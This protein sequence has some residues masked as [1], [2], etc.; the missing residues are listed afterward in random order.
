[1]IMK[2]RKLNFSEHI[3]NVLAKTAVKLNSI[4]RLAKYMGNNN[5]KNKNNNNKQFYL[6]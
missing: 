4:C 3:S 1:M 6:F 5:N 2:C